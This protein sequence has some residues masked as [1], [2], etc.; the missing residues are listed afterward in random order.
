VSAAVVGFIS[1]LRLSIDGWLQ[2]V[3]GL[4][5]DL[6][7]SSLYCIKWHLL[8]LHLQV[9]HVLQFVFYE[10]SQMCWFKYSCKFY[11]AIC[12]LN[13]YKYS[14]KVFQLLCWCIVCTSTLHYYVT[15]LCKAI[16][17]II[18]FAIYVIEYSHWSC[19]YQCLHTL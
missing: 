18:L 1:L 10:F 19:M 8:W 13:F 3:V 12:K 17:F 6:P 2:A 4:H 5:Q 9:K 14:R 7:F 11:I 15:F 16:Y